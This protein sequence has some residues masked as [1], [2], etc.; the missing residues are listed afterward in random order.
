[1]NYTVFF[2]VDEGPGITALDMDNNFG[3]ALQAGV[4]IHLRDRWYLNFDVKKLF[5]DT[6][7]VVAGLG[8]TETVNVQIDPWIVGVGLGYRFGGGYEPLK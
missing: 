5:L 6:D 4:D 8:A 7:V 1:M 2:N 3:W